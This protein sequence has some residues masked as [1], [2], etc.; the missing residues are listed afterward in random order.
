MNYSVYRYID[1]SIL[2]LVKCLNFYF[3]ENNSD[4]GKI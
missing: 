4:F 3:N 2:I 1:D